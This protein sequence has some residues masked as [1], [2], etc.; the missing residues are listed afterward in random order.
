MLRAI[1]RI[2]G[3][4]TAASV[5]SIWAKEWHHGLQ[6]PQIIQR[7]LLACRPDGTNRA[8]GVRH[9]RIRRETRRAPLL[10]LLAR[11]QEEAGQQLHDDAGS[12]AIID[13]AK[14]GLPG[15]PNVAEGIRAER[16]KAQRPAAAQ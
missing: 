1:V 14:Y 8:T 3:P 7:L 13:F 9:T 4:K 10:L 12:G 16:F 5:R 6:I 11:V 15:E 2:V